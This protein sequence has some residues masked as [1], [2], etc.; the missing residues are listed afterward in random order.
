MTLQVAAVPAQA[1]VDISIVPYGMLAHTL[2]QLGKYLKISADLTSGRSSVDDIVRLVMVGHYTLWV[3]FELQTKALIGFFATEVKQYPQRKLLN[4]Q[5]CVVEPQHLDEM[6]QVMEDYSERF[7]RDSGCSGIEFV[8]RPGWRRY[9]KKNG[10]ASH[11]VV[12]Q[13]FFDAEEK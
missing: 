2:G 6:E 1:R 4:I 11:A 10:Y 5:H 9:S 7:A 8:G 12:Y 3:V 13:R